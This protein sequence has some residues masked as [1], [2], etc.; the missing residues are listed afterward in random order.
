MLEYTYLPSETL[1]K[2]ENRGAIGSS[3]G[4]VIVSGYLALATFYKGTA[5]MFPTMTIGPPPRSNRQVQGIHPPKTT[6]GPTTPAP[7]SAPQK[8]EDFSEENDETNGT[9]EPPA[10][11]KLTIRAPI[12]Y[13][14]GA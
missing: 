14:A 3:M 1:G 9:P 11:E 4:V 13:H 2:L 10:Q 7:T 8:A 5:P 12:R 6:P